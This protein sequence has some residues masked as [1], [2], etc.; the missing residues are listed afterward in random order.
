H[1]IQQ[2]EIALQRAT[3]EDAIVLGAAM[4]ARER[5]LPHV[6][7]VEHVLSVR[8]QRVREIELPVSCRSKLP[9]TFAGGML[10]RIVEVHEP[11]RCEDPELHPFVVVPIGTQELVVAVVTRAT[12]ART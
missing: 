6:A 12:A 9:Q 1:S 2:V 3:R 5:S 10:P 11:R 7:E 4:R 8:E